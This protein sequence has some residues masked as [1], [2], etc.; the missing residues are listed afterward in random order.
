M[1][2]RKFAHRQF[3]LLPASGSQHNSQ[4]TTHKLRKADFLFLFIHYVYAG[5]VGA[6]EENKII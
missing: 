5:I 1:N 3:Y 2:G 6:A 4:F